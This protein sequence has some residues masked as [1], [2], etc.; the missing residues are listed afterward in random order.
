ML[1]KSLATALVT[2]VWITNVNSVL[3]PDSESRHACS[4]RRTAVST[5][6][7]GM[8]EICS[9][10][11]FSSLADEAECVGHVLQNG[12]FFKTDQS[13]RESNVSPSSAFAGGVATSCSAASKNWGAYG[14]FS[15]AFAALLAAEARRSSWSRRSGLLT[16]GPFSWCS[17]HWV[18]MVEF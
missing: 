18:N 4:K 15:T 9:H 6:R 16:V 2:T 8:L 11:V 12:R 1:C 17:H 7:I 10:T 14:G 13:P 5:I 3:E